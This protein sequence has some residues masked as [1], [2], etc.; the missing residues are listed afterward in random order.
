VRYDT[1]LT[2]ARHPP[3]GGRLC[4]GAAPGGVLP[5]G[6]GNRVM[7]MLLL[8]DE[9]RAAFAT[10]NTCAA[11]AT[12]RAIAV[13]TATASGVPTALLTSQQVKRVRHRSG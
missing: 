3:L 2:H 9:T 8:D 10:S 13:I 1:V 6:L 7:S 11:T 5:N 12:G 4:A